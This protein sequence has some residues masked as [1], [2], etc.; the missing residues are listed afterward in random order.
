MISY[1]HLEIDGL[2]KQMMYIMKWSLWEY[3]LQKGHNMILGFVATMVNYGVY[4]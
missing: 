2:V 4:V 1:D 3:G